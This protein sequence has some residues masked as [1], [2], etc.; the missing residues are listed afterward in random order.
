MTNRDPISAMTM[1][2]LKLLVIGLFFFLAGSSTAPA[3]NVNVDDK[4][5]RFGS[6]VTQH[7][8]VGAYIKASSTA[9]VRKA[10]ITIPVP[11]DWPEQ[12]V[13]IVEENMPGNV[14]AVKYRTLQNGVRQMLAEVTNVKAG[15]VIELSVTFEVATNTI[16]E[17]KDTDKWEIP[18]K[19][20][21]SMKSFLSKSPQINT[22]SMKLKKHAK[23]LVADVDGDWK[24]VE[25][26]YDWV[27]DNIK[28]TNEK[29][30]GA[31]ACL[32]HKEGPHEDI[33][34]LFVALCRANKIPTRTVWVEGN[35][36]AEFYLLDKTKK[37]VKDKKVE[38]GTWFPAQLVGNRDFGSMSDPRIIQQKGDNFRVP[39]E[40]KRQNYVYEHV[41]AKSKVRPTVKFI[42]KLIQK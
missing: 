35:V 22:T 19:L 15:Q 6:P 28:Q 10:Y 34:S 40:E 37:D 36:Y 21:R 26:I 20:P 11:M 32:R 39:E 1:L 16:N 2:K 38:K 5:S 4:N 14:T 9:S 33:V 29:P 42:R 8:K 12:K 31:V 27:R 24:K 13:R 41:T 30:E 18:T 7:W 3:Q 25:T 23:S 17:P